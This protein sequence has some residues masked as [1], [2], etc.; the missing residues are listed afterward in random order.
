L[1]IVNKIGKEQNKEGILKA[2][3]LH[4]KYQGSLGQEHKTNLKENLFYKYYR[5][6]LLSKYSKSLDKLN[7]YELLNFHSIE[8]GMKLNRFH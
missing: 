3:Y 4:S 2:L 1:K 6:Y 5:S 7:I 8:E